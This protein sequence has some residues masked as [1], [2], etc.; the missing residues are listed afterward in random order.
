[1]FYLAY[2]TTPMTIREADPDDDWDQGDDDLNPHG[3]TLVWCKDSLN[4]PKGY[5]DREPIYKPKA[6]KDA[7]SGLWV[8]FNIHSDGS[9][10]GSTEGYVD[11]VWAGQDKE[12]AEEA[13]SRAMSM[14]YGYFGSRTSTHCKFFP[15]EKQS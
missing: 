5:D 4:G 13:T 1:M 11:V 2:Q 8:V 3:F 7:A 14:D 9:T 12:E 6:L 15:V 10:F